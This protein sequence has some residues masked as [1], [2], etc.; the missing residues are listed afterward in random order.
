MLAK[1]DQKHGVPMGQVGIV[2]AWPQRYPRTRR[3]EANHQARVIARAEEVAAA[4]EEAKKRG[5]F[6]NKRLDQRLVRNGTIKEKS[7]LGSM[8]ANSL[9]LSGRAR[10]DRQTALRLPPGD[11]AASVDPPK[12]TI[13]QPACRVQQNC[14]ISWSSRST[15]TAMIEGCSARNSGVIILRRRSI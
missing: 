14:G 9:Q 12:A 13:S 1:A 2:R 6:A 3:H 15:A 4:L 11:N 8:A 10:T 7:C 5:E